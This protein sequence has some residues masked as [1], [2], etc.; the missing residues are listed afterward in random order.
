MR[1]IETRQEPD[2]GRGASQ[3]TDASVKNIFMNDPDFVPLSAPVTMKL[4][5][6]DCWKLF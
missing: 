3:E 5:F 6:H 2:G 4:I 1:E